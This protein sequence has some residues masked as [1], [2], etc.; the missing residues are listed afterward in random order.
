MLKRFVRLRGR[1][2][3]EL[4]VRA[5]QASRACV[6]RLQMAGPRWPFR[7]AHVVRCAAPI[8]PR[9]LPTFAS[10]AGD[11]A[12]PA[13]VARA[14]SLRDR[15]AIVVMRMQA[16][17][18]REGR[19]TLLGCGAMHVGNPPRWDTDPSTAVTAPHVHWSRIRYLDPSVVGD[20]KVLWELNR[21]QY[22][23][24]AATCALADGNSVAFAL[25]QEHLS[26]WLKAN[27][28]NAGVNWCSSL[29]VSYRAITWCWLLWLLRGSV[30][31][32]ELLAGMAS[33]LEA[34][35]LHIERYLST[36][37]SPNTHLTGEALGLFYLGT[38]LS[39]SRHASRWRARGARILEDSLDRQVYPDGVYFEQTTQYQRYTCEIYLHYLQLARSTGWQ[40]ATSIAPRIVRAC[41]VVRAMTDGS[42]RMPLIGDDDGGLLLPLDHRAPDETAGLL[43]AAAVCLRRPDLAPGQRVHPALSYWLNGVVETESF[44]STGLRD[45]IWRSVHC[46]NGGI[47]VIRD[48]WQCGDAVCV[49]DAGPHGALNCGHAH[50]DALALTLTLGD[51]PLFIDRGTL[52]YVGHE[53]NEYRST[54]SHNTLEFDHESSVRP[55]S[56]FRWGTVPARPISSMYIAADATVLEASAA[57]HPDGG[58]PSRHSRIV[59]HLPGGAWLVSDQGFRQAPASAIARW[60]LAPGLR[61]DLD[62]PRRARIRPA[63]GAVIAFV[64]APVCSSLGIMQRDVSPRFGE[65]QSATLLEVAADRDLRALTLVVAPAGD[66]GAEGPEMTASDAGSL[67]TWI[68]GVGVNHLLVPSACSGGFELGWCRGEADAVWWKRERAAGAP[69]LP[70]L[71][72]IVRPRRVDFGSGNETPGGG[73]GPQSVL[74]WKYV[75]DGWRTVALQASSARGAER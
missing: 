28:A 7:A 59:A 25:V 73:G 75:G 36:Y 27:P 55:A 68:D 11:D 20:H 1:S 31:K 10:I 47:A 52:T 57:G 38:V 50:A 67:W 8:I 35:G 61:A 53:R 19:V 37:F 70:D 33:S 69:A 51:R 24:A 4:L 74:V 22:L 46:H 64:A 14:L 18:A 60:Q 26:S 29:E 6:E 43:L 34:H 41:E 54:V 39:Q 72:L 16:Q 45:P 3:D 15:D 42:G 58:R 23:L 17:A 13:E 49:I 44:L 66:I 12:R 71:V 48:G 21:H 9:Q 30:W 2:L 65:R 32:P 56:S 63:D 5:G 62:T 40:V